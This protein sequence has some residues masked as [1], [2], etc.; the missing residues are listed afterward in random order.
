MISI[1]LIVVGIMPGFWLLNLLPRTTFG[2]YS[3]SVYFTATA[4]IALVGIAD[5]TAILLLNF[6]Q[7]VRDRGGSLK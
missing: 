3:G 7:H 2:G 4:M 1:P 6:I 5:C